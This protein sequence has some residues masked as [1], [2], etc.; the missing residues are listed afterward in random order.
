MGASLL[1]RLHVGSAV[2]L[3]AAAMVVTTVAA[4]STEARSSAW[5]SSPSRNIGCAMTTTRVRCDV[6]SRSWVP[7]PK[8]ASCD[9]AWGPALEVGMTSTGHFG[10]VSD[11]VGGSPRI[12]A[13]GR[14]LTIGRF[15]CT[16]RSTDMT[17][18]DTANGHGFRVSR[19][20]YRLF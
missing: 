2:L 20:L 10:C 3:L 16:S 1:G 11:T 15:R 7:T 6:I 13:Y 19:V 5:F 4:P 8:P 14:S 17:C 9:F 12:L 18:V